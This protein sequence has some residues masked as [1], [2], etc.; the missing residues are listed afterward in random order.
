MLKIKTHIA[1][2]MLL[3]VA[4]C[5]MFSGCYQE[6]AGHGRMMPEDTV[7]LADTSLGCPVCYYSV[8][9]NFVVR[10]DSLKLISNQPEIV[11]TGMM[12]D[13]ISV[14]CGDRLVVADI[15]VIP[16]DTIDLVWVKVARDQETIGWAPE[17]ELLDAVVPDDSISQFIQTFSDAHLLTFLIIISI[18]S[19]AYLM[20]TVFRRKAHIVHFNDIPSLYPTLLAVIVAASAALYSSI[21]MFVPGLWQYFYYHPTLN[22]F[23]LPGILSLFLAAVWAILII[24]MGSVDVVFKELPFGDAMLYLCGLAGVCAINYIVFSITTLYFVGYLLL[25]AYIFFA[26][27]LYFN[28]SHYTCICG[29]CGARMHSKG[30]CVACGAMNE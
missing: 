1:I 12:A 24:A 18:I 13:S 2:L 9:Y 29:N 21:Q 5:A 22:P 25:A 6:R 17:T 3:A 27:R 19:V 14:F 7:A 15:R 26:F 30:R 11:L 28:R 16:S 10:A 4:A 20:R 8:N 23:A